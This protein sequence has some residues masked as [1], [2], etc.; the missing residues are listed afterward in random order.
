MAFYLTFL[1]YTRG[2]VQREGLH[3]Q[4]ETVICYV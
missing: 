4:G 3:G 1:C 2:H